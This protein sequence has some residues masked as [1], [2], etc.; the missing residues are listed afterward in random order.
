M[1]EIE[2]IVDYLTQPGMPGLKGPLV[3]SEGFPLNNVDLYSVRQMRQ[4]YNILN[5]D[6]STIM[7]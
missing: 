4:R 6:Y 5:N 2:E 7:K 3:D 1:K